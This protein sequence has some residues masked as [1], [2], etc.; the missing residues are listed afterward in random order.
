MSKATTAQVEA[1]ENKKIIQKL[2]YK[3]FKIVCNELNVV[4]DAIRELWTLAKN[5]KDDRVKKDIYQ[6][7]IEMNIGKAKQSTDIT[8]KDERI[9]AGIFVDGDI[10]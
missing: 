3:D 8:S 6:W 1:S 5:T 2:D 9:T 4:E 7:I 10:N